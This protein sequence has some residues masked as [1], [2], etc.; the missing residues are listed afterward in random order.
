MIKSTIFKLSAAAVIIS[1]MSA[2]ATSSAPDA[3]SAPEIAY[4]KPSASEIEQISYSTPLEQAGF[5]LKQYNL[6]PTDLD[7]SVAYIHALMKIKSYEEA[8]EVA[9]FTSVTF[10]DN[11]HVWTL[12]GRAYNKQ[13]KPV[14]AVKAYGKVVEIN[15][16]DAAPL[17]AMGAIF[18]SR[19]DHATA[20]MAY[21]RALKLDPNR[22]FTLAN[23]GLSLSL[24]GKLEQAEEALARA[25]EMEGATAAVR[26]NYAL[27]L[28]LRGKF[29]EARKI[30][31]IDAPERVADRNAAFLENMIGDNPRLKAIAA[32]AERTAPITPVSN[33]SVQT[34]EI[35]KAAPTES[36]TSS[37]LPAVQTASART[38]QKTP[39]PVATTQ[40]A[41]KPTLALRT[42]KR[43]APTDGED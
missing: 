37:A 42:R 10:P 7:I 43:A 35:P 38:V 19:G 20:Q 34:A 24:V 11:A 15:P 6:H 13:D 17:A 21:E 16:E 28:G 29:D 41:P 32:K 18:D 26:Q 33:I 22:P 30:A 12:L 9:K 25:T 4:E 14:E 1:A 36:L 23:Y 3:A 40:A 31:S 5:W 2:C 39:A 8:V 27:V